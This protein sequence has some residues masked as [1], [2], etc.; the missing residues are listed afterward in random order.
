MKNAIETT[1]KNGT[2][3]YEIPVNISEDEREIYD[4][5]KQIMEGI[6]NINY[7]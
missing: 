7:N 2:L 1:I 5:L 6:F 4:E 3:K